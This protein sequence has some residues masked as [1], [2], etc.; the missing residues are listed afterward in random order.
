MHLGLIRN[1]GEVRVKKIISLVLAAALIVLTAF[2]G[3]SVSPAMLPEILTVKTDESGDYGYVDYSFV[4]SEGNEI[5]IFG[6]K[7]YEPEESSDVS[8]YSLRSARTVVPESYD[9]RDVNC[10]TSVKQQGVSGNCW[11]FSGMSMLE[12]DA[13]LKGIDDAESADYSEAHFSWFTSRSLTDNTE[14]STYGDG[15]TDEAPF[16]TGGNWIIAAGSLARWTGAAEDTDYPFNPTDL[17]AMGNYDESCR[18]DTGSGIIIE[19]AEELLNME[20]AKEWIMAH[21][22]ATLAFYFDTAYYNSSTAAYYYNG[23]N[24]LNHEITVV[25][26][27]DNFLSSDF[28]E[29]CMPEGNGAWLC[30]NSWGTNWGDNGYFWIS[31]YDTSID[32]FAGISARSA[33]DAYRNYTYNGAG[34]ESYIGH[35]GTAKISNVFTA[36]GPELLT[37]VSTYTMTPAQEVN[38]RIYKNLPSAYTNPESGELALEYSTVLSRSGYHTVDLEDEVA[39]EQG[40]IFSVVIEYVTDGTVYIPVEAN[41]QGMNAYACNACESYV[42][43]PA[44]NEGWY[45]VMIY[46][47]Q[48]VFVQAFTVCNHQSTQEFLEAT[49][50]ETGI[51]TSTCSLCGQ[52]VSEKII[53]AMGH[54]FSDWTD[55]VHD[56]ETDK[57]VSTRYCLKCGYTETSTIVYSKNT[58]RIDD[59]IDMIFERIIEFLRQMF[60]N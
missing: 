43:L 41:G 34:W 26:W 23:S 32:Q 29:S 47:F 48:N 59:L 55:Y 19:S 50:V 2:S 21:G 31:Y 53:P 5:G 33:K 7:S 40:T 4:D 18:Y 38:V 3:T 44:Y 22:S 39:L 36:K 35:T 46:G 8:F 17:P 15:R 56:F 37:A 42:C 9:S 1:K 24:T 54:N 25:G 28:N 57:E 60:R 30:K 10:I 27:D 52:I 58:V 14:D 16:V 45:D 12:S 11:A 49:C 51:E 20:D 13:I 6:D